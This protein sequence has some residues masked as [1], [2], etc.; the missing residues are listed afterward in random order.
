[1]AEVGTKMVYSRKNW[2]SVFSTREEM[3]QAAAAHTSSL[4]NEMLAE[5]STINM[6]F[7]AAPSQDEFLEALGKDYEI[8]WSRIRAFHMD[9][10][11]GLPADASQLFKNYLHQHLFGRVAFNSYHY[12]DDISSD[13]PETKAREYASILE[14]FPI[15]IVCMG[16]GENGHVAF[17]DPPLADFNDPLSVKIVQLTKKCRQQQVNDGCF[18][19]LALVP[20]EAITVSVSLLLSAKRIVCVVPGRQKS[21]AV[22]KAL[23]G[24]I[25]KDCPASILRVHPH[26]AMFLDSESAIQLKEV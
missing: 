9:E 14:Q 18:K 4:I 26:L 22:K 6:M 23:D 13:D 11:I 1:M 25:S 5:N 15:D 17:N 21:E 20:T 12:I 3:G 8:N 19:K 7:A 16:I 10:Y 2:I 24:P